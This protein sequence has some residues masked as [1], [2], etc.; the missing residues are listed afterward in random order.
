[1]A[2][3]VI[4]LLLF[5]SFMTFITFTVGMFSPKTVKCQT[6]GKAALIYLSASV[7]CFFWACAII[8]ITTPKPD[9]IDEM[10][11]QYAIV[12]AEMADAAAKDE[13]YMRSQ[14]A[15]KSAKETESSIGKPVKVGHFIYTVQNIAFRKSVGDEFL[16]ETADGIYMLVNLSIKNVSEETRTLDGSF[17][18]VTDK[19]GIKYEF[20]TDAATALEM[21]GK[22]PLFLKD[23]QPNITTKGVLIFEVPQKSEYYLHLIG[24]FWGEQSV[25][26]LLR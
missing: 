3:F 6:R 8:S 14:Q 25:R 23:C 16:E 1:M 7:G 9:S 2:N 18:A 12:A 26:I 22:K 17:F 13:E 4:L 11:E 10:D 20:S 15:T 19:K 24:S 5:G 21:S